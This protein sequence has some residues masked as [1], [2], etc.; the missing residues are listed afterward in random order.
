[1]KVHEESVI[2]PVAI[3]QLRRSR[4]FIATA[5]LLTRTPEERY[6]SPTILRSYGAYPIDVGSRFL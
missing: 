6:A 2:Q 5:G 4:M 1:M 3:V